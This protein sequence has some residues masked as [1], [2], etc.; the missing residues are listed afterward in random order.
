L[1]THAAVYVKEHV[2]LKFSA[3]KS[4]L[5]CVYVDI[6]LEQLYSSLATEAVKIR[7]N[8]IQNK[9]SVIDG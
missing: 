7:Q 5:T 4:T 3:W 1:R 2:V 6:I 8:K 9:T